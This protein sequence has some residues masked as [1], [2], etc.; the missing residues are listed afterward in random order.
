MFETVDR[1]ARLDSLKIPSKL[2]SLSVSENTELKNVCRNIQIKNWNKENLKYLLMSAFGL[3][4]S[5]WFRKNGAFGTN[6]CWLM[7]HQLN[8]KILRRHQRT[9]RSSCAI[10]HKFPPK[11]ASSK[12]IVRLKV[13]SLNTCLKY[14][15]SWSE[16]S[17][18]PFHFK[19]WCCV[20][21]PNALRNWPPLRNGP[22]SP[23]PY[24]NW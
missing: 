20:H 4:K 8:G 11:D 3:K 1:E 17:K 6:M 21:W 2:N 10:W 24:E 9:Y 16:I 7:Q 23:W 19:W 18:L 13:L 12:F 15:L 14:I 22:R 5:R